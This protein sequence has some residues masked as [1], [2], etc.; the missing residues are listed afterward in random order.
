[1]NN[2]N[3]TKG[4]IRH[5]FKITETIQR[6]YP[7]LY[8]NLIETPLF[9]SVLEPKIT[10]ENYTEYLSSLWLQLKTFHKYHILNT[11]Q[12]S[13]DKGSKNHKKAAVQGKTK[14]ISAY[15][16][17]SKSKS[18]TLDLSDLKIGGKPKNQ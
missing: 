11:I 1:M 6:Q 3:H 13:K 15:K 12:M 14:V 4:L 9:L 7:E 17:E 8:E 16:S 2:G 5:I 10:D 18:S